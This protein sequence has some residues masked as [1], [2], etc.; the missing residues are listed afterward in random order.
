MDGGME[1]C[2][3]I[4]CKLCNNLISQKCP[5]CQQQLNFTNIINKTTCPSCHNKNINSLQ[6]MVVN[7]QEEKNKQHK[8]CGLVENQIYYFYCTQC[9]SNICNNH[10]NSIQ[11]KQ[12]IDNQI[13]VDEIIEAIKQNKNDEET[14][15]KIDEKLENTNLKQETYCQLCLFKIVMDLKKD[16]YQ[17]ARANLNALQSKINDINQR[18]FMSSLIEPF[19]LFNQFQT[20][21]IDKDKFLNKNKKITQFLQQQKLI[22]VNNILK[23]NYQDLEKLID[24]IKQNCEKAE[25]Q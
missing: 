13:I 10:D 16:N 18:D 21:K 14:M 17:L 23:F 25:S 24:N 7:P 1:F 3:S 12:K 6:L 9:N 8:Q 20:Q 5:K 2:I 15:Q 19:E 22:V 11:S 4:N